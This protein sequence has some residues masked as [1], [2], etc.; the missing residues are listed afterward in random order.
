MTKTIR[1]SSDATICMVDDDGELSAAIG[2]D[3][4]AY[5]LGADLTQDEID[6]LDH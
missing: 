2:E 1:Y 4:D 3:L 6:T 5:P